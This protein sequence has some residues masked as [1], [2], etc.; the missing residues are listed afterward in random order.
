MLQ[1]TGTASVLDT[2]Y[3][4]RIGHV[5]EL[6]RMGADIHVINGRV[7][8]RGSAHLTGARVKATDLRAGAA[9]IIAGLI[10]E[11]VTEIEQAEFIL[12]GY[13]HVVEN[14]EALGADIQLVEV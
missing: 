14:L 13:S 3:P 1:A 9:M 12:R 10:A 11:G 2:I 4:D 6:A 8:Y 7:F 5:Q